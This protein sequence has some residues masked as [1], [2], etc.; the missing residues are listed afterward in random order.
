MII[1]VF[2]TKKIYDYDDIIISLTI[3]KADEKYNEHVRKNGKYV[4]VFK[5]FNWNFRH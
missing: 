3:E 5:Y 1:T 2:T 4:Q